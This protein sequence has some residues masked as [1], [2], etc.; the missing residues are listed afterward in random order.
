MRSVKIAVAGGSGFI[1]EPLVRMLLVRGDDVAV[2]TRNPS[3][4]RAGRPL[5][6]DAKTQGAWSNEVATADVVINLAGENIGEGRWTES[7][8]RKLIDSRINAT[9][10]LVEAMSTVRAKK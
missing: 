1:G 4:V 8:K 9:R 6:W 2:L 10:A 7:R 5:E 3:K